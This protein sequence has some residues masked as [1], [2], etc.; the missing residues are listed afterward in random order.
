MNFNQIIR[1]EETIVRILHKDWVVDG[2]MQI[3]A[4]ALRPNETYISVNRQAVNTFTQEVHLF[5]TNHPDYYIPGYE[6][7]YRQAVMNVGNVR[8]IQIELGQ[9]IL[10]VSVDVEPRSLHVF[11]H[12]GIFTLF[13]GKYIKGGQQADIQV[14]DSRLMPVKAIHL[15][16]QYALLALSKMEECNIPVRE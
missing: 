5:V 15:K 3:N 4:F 10:N 9:Q 8:G 6:L 12:A 13:E 14:D 16:V 7:A 1:D 11:S 2:K